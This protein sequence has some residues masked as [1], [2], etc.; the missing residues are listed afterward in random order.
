ML[1]AI[2]KGNQF[3]QKVLYIVPLEIL[4]PDYLN[5]DA[6]LIFL[7]TPVTPT[8]AH[9]ISINLYYY[10]LYNFI[11][12]ICSFVGVIILRNQN[13]RYKHKNN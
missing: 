13:A 1:A 7:I 11:L 8:N 9:I 10:I 4:R 5:T 6:Y 12:I 2:Y 3:R